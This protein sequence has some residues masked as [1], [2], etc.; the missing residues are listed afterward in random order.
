MRKKIY[1]LRLAEK[2]IYY[3]I[4]STTNKLQDEQ[5]KNNI[6][7]LMINKIHIR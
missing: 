1:L 4:K 6:C 7:L 3:R 2:Q 5:N